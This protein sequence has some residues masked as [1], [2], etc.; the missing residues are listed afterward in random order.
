MTIN[1]HCLECG[2]NLASGWERQIC[3]SCI[4]GE[5]DPIPAESNSSD[6]TISGHEILD[7]IARGGMGI[8]YKA[9]DPKTER[10]VAL[11]V[12][13][14]HIADR[15]GMRER[16]RIEA[17][18]A[19]S[20]DHPAILPVYLVG[21]TSELPFMT[22]RLAPG[23]SLAEQR[24]H[25]QGKYKNLARLM[26]T[27]ADAVHFAHSHGI[28]HRDIK[29]ENILFDEDHKPY[30]SDFGLAKMIDSDSQLTQTIQF[31]GTPQYTAPEVASASANAASVS[32]DIWSLGAILHEL[33]LGKP[34][35]QG[36][37][38]PS[39][40]RA[41]VEEEPSLS[42][43]TSLSGGIPRDLKIICLKCLAKK[44]EDRYSSANDLAEDLRSWL[45]RR[46]IKARPRS[47]FEKTSH[48]IRSN[49]LLTLLTLLLLGA[50]ITLVIFKFRESENTRLALADSLLRE[51]QLERQ[52]GHFDRR[53]AAWEAIKKASDINPGPKLRDEFISLLA[54]PSLKFEVLAEG[55]LV[56]HNYSLTSRLIASLADN[57]VEIRHQDSKELVS[58][59]PFD[60][61]AYHIVG[62]FTPDDRYL[63]LRFIDRMEFR[64]VQTGDL[65]LTI[66]G[67]R[68]SLTFDPAGA[69]MAYARFKKTIEIIDLNQTPPVAR[70]LG[71]ETER[72]IPKAFSPDGK[73]LAVK[74]E[75]TS[76]PALLLIDPENGA[77]IREV[78]VPR[79]GNTQRA[80]FTPDGKS[81]FAAFHGGNIHHIPL[82]ET[83]PTRVFSGHSDKVTSLGIINKGRILISQSEDE[84]T[85]LWDTATGETLSIL[86]WS[87]AY[88]VS[89]FTHDNRFFLF[90]GDELVA[91]ELIP[92]DICTTIALPD[93]DPDFTAPYGRWLI[94]S[95]PDGS[96]FAV[97]AMQ[98][99]H[100]IKSRDWEISQSFSIPA[101]FDLAYRQDESTLIA[102]R[103]QSIFKYHSTLFHGMK[104]KIDQYPAP[105][106]SHVAWAGDTHGTAV[107]WKATGVH[108]SKNRKSTPIKLLQ[109][110]KIHDLT[111]SPD[112]TILAAATDKGIV[113]YSLATPTPSLLQ[114]LPSASPRNLVLLSDNQTLFSGN[115]HA[116]H[117][118]DLSTGTTD[119]S[120]PHH[121]DSRI[122]RP[123]AA[124]DD[125]SLLAISLDN[126]S[127]SLIDGDT[128]QILARLEHPNRHRVQDVAITPDGKHVA[129]LT[130]GHLVKIWHLD[131]LGKALSKQGFESPLKALQE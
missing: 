24:D 105:T 16:F 29:P 128:G 112:A 127:V 90:R 116:F 18:A 99:L 22:M 79:A 9:F 59:I 23:G 74:R 71:P 76:P 96:T 84:T 113:I 82:D 56:D 51:A 87:G 41:I 32:S 85:R 62:P 20:L 14:P 13:L 65:V 34:P 100:L 15:P 108:F 17:K 1:R 30:L 117:R 114:K 95:N 109:N 88:H 110:Q 42:S 61:K 36:E 37:S 19:A 28:L 40:L 93:P 121:L 72:L 111:S 130:T 97:S 86:P 33:L 80:V 107:S 124:T 115:A 53:D 68:F 92:S 118:W 4:L 7:E 69:Q 66:P 103:T 122:H 89:S 131:L 101:V 35:F 5:N 39:L 21:D 81:F 47:L 78:P 102:G 2:E 12:L 126:D 67:Q 60:P 94:K 55:P 52:T 10:L 27:L 48:L 43:T 8:V 73:T 129:V 119:W 3:S 6:H 38:I 46:P 77:L 98:N 50:F 31:L 120:L 70:D 123:L 75:H 49:P 83:Q 91:G 54:W 106:A 63:I 58:S 125:G 104:E 26:A 57:G 44:P 45:D 64:D 25:W 11:K